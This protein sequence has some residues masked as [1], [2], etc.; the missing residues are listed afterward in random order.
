MMAAE[1]LLVF[2]NTG[3]IKNSVNYPTV[4]IPYTNDTRI[5]LA[6]KNIANV[7]S[8]ITGIISAEGINI[9]NFSNGSKGDFAY[10]IVEIKVP[11]PEGIIPRLEQIEGMIKVRVV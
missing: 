8:Q 7:L 6:H 5:C 1:E 3:N 4:S 9:E 11:V 2:L 10:T